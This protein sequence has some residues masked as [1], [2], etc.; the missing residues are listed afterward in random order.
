MCLWQRMTFSE[1][2]IGCPHSFKWQCRSVVHILC[3]PV[4]WW[5]SD[6]LPAQ[7]LCLAVSH[8]AIKMR[9]WERQRL[10]Q[11]DAT[12]FSCT[13]YFAGLLWVAAAKAKLFKNSNSCTPCTI[14]S[15]RATTHVTAK[16]VVTCLSNKV[17]LS[18]NS[19]IHSSV[20]ELFMYLLLLKYLH[21]FT[22]FKTT[23]QHF[24]ISHYNDQL[25]D[26]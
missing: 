23:I 7:I 18:L 26:H 12:L 20:K 9:A 24:L 17:G 8:T 4:T 22:V 21:C 5:T 25:L 10:K 2:S 11:R 16:T 1:C 14:T 15:S 6:S 13:D 3:P 19:F